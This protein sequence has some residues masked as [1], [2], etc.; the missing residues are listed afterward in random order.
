[1]GVFHSRKKGQNWQFKHIVNMSSAYIAILIAGIGAFFRHLVLPGN[2]AAGGVASGI[3]SV[4]LIPIMV[5]LTRRY[6]V[7]NRGK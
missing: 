3:L 1:M 5:L 7:R 6:K 2:T 4:I